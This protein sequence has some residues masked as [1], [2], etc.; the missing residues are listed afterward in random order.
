MFANLKTRT[1][2]LAGT[3]APLA[4]TAALAGVALW[5]LL[6]LSDSAAWVSH[7]NR[8]ISKADA[9]VASA[10]DMET[11][12][13]GYLLA[14]RE[15]FLEPYNAGQARAYEQIGALQET[16]SDN[17][18]QVAR[19]GE[20][21]QVL[22]DWQA[23]AAEPAIA[24]RRAIGDAATMNDL[25][26]LVGEARGKVFFDAFRTQI[27]IFIERER[28][29][30]VEREEELNALKAAGTLSAAEIEEAIGW[31]THTYRVIASANE[32]LA[33][34]VDMET[35]MRGFLL[36]GREDFLEPY[37][38][39]RAAFDQRVA[40]LQET[41]SDNP[42][43]VQ[44]LEEIAVTIG[45]WQTEVTEPMIALRRD[46]G[47]AATMD[48]MADLIAEARGKVFFDTFRGL[49]ADF[50]AEEEGLMVG[51]QAEA[52]RA[53]ALTE[54]TI[55]IGGVLTVALGLL[56]AL[57]VGRGIANPIDSMTT[58]MQ[59]LAK[60]E[61]DVDI[62][63]AGRR[64]EIG[65]MADAVQVFRDNAAEVKRLE[66]AQQRSQAAAAEQR[67]AEMTQLAD[68]FEA[69]V[70]GIVQSVAGA[71]TQVKSS[72]D[73][74]AEQAGQSKRTADDVARA[75]E[76]AASNVQ[77]VASAAEEL[78]SSINEISG[79][80]VQSTDIA[81][82]AVAEAAR[83][84]QIMEGLSETAEQVGEV[85]DMINQIADQTNLLA[86]NATIEAAR[87]GEAGKGFAVVASE[88]KNLA[89]QTGKAT[90]DITRQIGEMRT[91]LNTAVA[92]NATITG[93]I[94]EI[95]EITTTVASAVEEQG[96]ATQEIA[97]NVEQA[98]SGTHEV[99]TNMSSVIDI[100]QDT[101]T[102][103][104]Q[105]QQAATELAEISD[106][107]RDSVSSFIGQV[108]TA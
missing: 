22:R 7:T 59:R 30:L 107:L 53:Q 14:G 5:G 83:T 65:D 90:E 43:Q 51:R 21:E 82:R 63:G 38:G 78:S 56:L 40:A 18:A 54:G 91:A 3:L 10:V 70:G 48:D 9:I 80:V 87:A 41:V 73:K 4:L 42:A 29:L 77:T 24:L 19:L 75:S 36:A 50:R 102:S 94:T 44:L 89:D 98:A 84:N 108:R 27:A 97:R 35:G 12:M 17:P 104:T 66:E 74:L 52:D 88:V 13:R 106:R 55:M 72:S 26:S 85:V 6:T 101:G 99:N 81:N 69:N 62:P 64:D 76:H 37:D 57:L 31:V 86:L 15:E 16:V 103:A 2:V 45:T 33:A 67:R 28:S 39:G 11:G 96:S 49:M 60:G 95:N 105:M 25:A 46:I 32:I 61:L 34:A 93:I 8:V 79:Q 47:D 92:A 23:N 1:K 100:A 20:V 58:V 68:A 71:S